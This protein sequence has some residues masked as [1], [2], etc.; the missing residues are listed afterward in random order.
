MQTISFEC[1]YLQNIQHSGDNGY[2]QFSDSFLASAEI[3]S[4]KLSSMFK[5]IIELRNSP[6]QQWF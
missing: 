1:Y 4:A 2:R 6:P 5:G 3:P